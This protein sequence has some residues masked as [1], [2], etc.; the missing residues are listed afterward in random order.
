MSVKSYQP[1]VEQPKL[2][3][4]TGTPLEPPDADELATE[5]R[6]VTAVVIRIERSLPEEAW[7]T[8][9]EFCGCIAGHDCCARPDHQRR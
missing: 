2:E 3:N 1:T 8:A 9:Q 4:K 5:G 6:N 7:V